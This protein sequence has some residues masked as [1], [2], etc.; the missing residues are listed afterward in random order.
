MSKTF[1][2]DYY[3]KGSWN[4]ICDRC[5]FKYKGDELKKEWQGLMVCATCFEPRHPQDLIRSVRDQRLRPYYRPEPVA[6]FIPSILTLS[7]DLLI[8]ADGD[9]LISSDGEPLLGSGE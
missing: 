5:G 8:D 2:K 3:K 9:V 4:V 6:V 1:A 7:V